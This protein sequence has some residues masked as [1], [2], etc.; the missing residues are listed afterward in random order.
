VTS[1][2]K[3]WQT[4]CGRLRALRPRS[5][6]RGRPRNG[7]GSRSESWSS[8]YR[9]RLVD[10]RGH[11][12]AG[13]FPGQHGDRRGSLPASA[14]SGGRCLSERY[15]PA[16][17]VDIPSTGQGYRPARSSQIGPNARPSRRRT[18]WERPSHALPDRGIEGQLMVQIARRSSSRAPFARVADPC[19]PATQPGS[20]GPWLLSLG[21]GALV[22]RS[23]SLA[24][25]RKMLS[26]Y[27]S[28][29]DGFLGSTGP[30]ASRPGSPR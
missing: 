15:P 11:L 3:S 16:C 5:R 29:E 18:F 23:P 19:I 30:C 14:L 25:L 9:D 22:R 26:A 13:M 27:P 24:G 20:A 8:E 2:D 17:R 4:R 7:Y 12:D 10:R 6:R 1:P 28:P 21:A